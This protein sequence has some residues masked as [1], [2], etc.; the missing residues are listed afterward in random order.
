MPDFH[1][2]SPKFIPSTTPI[3]GDKAAAAPSK[4]AVGKDAAG[5]KVTIEPKDKSIGSGQDV[6]KQQAD[7]KEGNKLGGRAA[8][9]EVGKAAA[10]KVSKEDMAVFKGQTEVRHHVM[11]RLL[12]DEIEGR[13]SDRQLPSLDYNK[14]REYF[15]LIVEKNKD[16][17]INQL[18]EETNKYIEDNYETLKAMAPKL[19][20][21]EESQMSPS[22]YTKAALKFS[23]QWKD[24]KDMHTYLSKNPKNNEVVESMKKRFQGYEHDSYNNKAL[25]LSLKEDVEN[26]R[27]YSAG[28]ED[29]TEL[30]Q[31]TAAEKLMEPL[32]VKG[33]SGSDHRFLMNEVK[34]MFYKYPS[35]PEK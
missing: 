25:F 23:E 27:K 11:K 30:M 9:G 8:A 15:K 3:T 1:T 7:T 32:A 31:L 19:K 20:K 24:L 29:Y 12:N 16:G 4:P 34:N 33:G 13:L 14:N 17:S 2:D 26:L 6:L 28:D 21:D 18:A 22:Q 35:L 10:G 5:K